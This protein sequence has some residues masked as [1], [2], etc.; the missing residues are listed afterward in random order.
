[1]QT[2]LSIAALAVVMVVGL[3]VHRHRSGLEG[4]HIDNEVDTVALAV[5]TD[6]LNRAS[7]L[8]FDDVAHVL[9]ASVLTAPSA[10]GG[11]ATWDDAADLDDVHGLTDSVVVAAHGRSLPYA[12]HTEVRYVALAGGAFVASAAQTPYKELTVTVDGPDGRRATL[13]RVYGCRFNA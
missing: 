7:V 2:L 3:A 4:R 13:A 1:M 5:A 12:V 11:A 10:F 9:D 8:P 6:H